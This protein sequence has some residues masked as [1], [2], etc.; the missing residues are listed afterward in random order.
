MRV[1]MLRQV[2]RAAP[3]SRQGVAAVALPRAPVVPLSRTT[4]ATLSAGVPRRWYGT[5]TIA[6]IDKKTLEMRLQHAA[7]QPLL[8]LDVRE[9]FELVHGAFPGARNIPLGELTTA[10]GLRPGEFQRK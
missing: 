4:I 2:V 8:F 7:T 6:I 9:P 1:G 5:E 10:F 3:F